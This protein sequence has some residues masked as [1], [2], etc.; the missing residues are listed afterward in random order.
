[1]ILA[2]F[3]HGLQASELCDLRWDQIEFSAAVLHVRR[4]KN[5]TSTWPPEQV[6]RWLRRL[7]GDG[8][9]STTGR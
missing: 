3:R 8:G 4:V 6:S 5:G 9:T 1:M 2:A 7:N